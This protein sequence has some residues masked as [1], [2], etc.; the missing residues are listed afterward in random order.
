M[1][2]IFNSDHFLVAFIDVLG[3]S[4]KILENSTYPPTEKALIKMKQNLLETSEYV[5]SLR[6]AFRNHFKKYRKLK[7][8]LEGL[9]KK[10][11]KIEQI[12]GTY[13][14]ELLGVSDSVI[15]SVPLE[16]KT[17][18]CI[19]MNNILATFKGIC[20]IYNI[21]LASHKPIRGGIDI[22]WG[23]RLSQNEV[24]GSALVKAYSLE[25]KEAGYPR[26]IVGES[27]WKYINYVENLKSKTE[28]G[29]RAV[30]IAKQCKGF[31]VDDHDDKH[32]LDVI[33]KAANSSVTSINPE[34]VKDG[35]H[36]IVAF[37]LECKQKGDK[38]LASRYKLLEN[39]FKPRLSLWGIKKV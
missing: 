1:K 39:Y 4:N 37:Q 12:M 21:A 25:T 29:I 33:G 15:I 34:L 20:L 30:K 13:S 17:D 27:L 5:M 3:Q 26:I 19:P 23:T 31:V 32:I 11:R 10:Q 7:D 18:N 8:V 6:D 16:N 14:A 36:H 35:Y 2:H 9:P 28:F 22:G 38:K 24:Y